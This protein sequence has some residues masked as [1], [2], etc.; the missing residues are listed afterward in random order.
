MGTV[1]IFEG[2]IPVFKKQVPNRCKWLF[3]SFDNTLTN[4]M[5]ISQQ[6]FI[7]ILFE[8]LQ[9]L[10]FSSGLMKGFCQLLRMCL[11]FVH[12]ASCPFPLLLCIYQQSFEMLFSQPPFFFIT[13]Y[14]TV[15]ALKVSVYILDAVF[16]CVWITV[17]GKLSYRSLK[18]LPDLNVNMI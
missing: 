2:K 15:S 9:Y 18:T 16:K 11:N 12:F 6:C 14:F 7:C 17:L 1:F 10:V 5:S 3:Y 8:V 4:C 13:L